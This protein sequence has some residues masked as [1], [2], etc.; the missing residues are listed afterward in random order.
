MFDKTSP[1]YDGNESIRDVLTVFQHDAKEFTY[2]APYDV[3]R[4]KF[5]DELGLTVDDERLEEMEYLGLNRD[6]MFLFFD[7]DWQPRAAFLTYE[8]YFHYLIAYC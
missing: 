6:N 3:S 1:S 4:L 7:L 2:N 8:D 5:D